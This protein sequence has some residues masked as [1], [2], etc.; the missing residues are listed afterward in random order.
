MNQP[1][2]PHTDTIPPHTDTVTPSTDPVPSCIN[3]Y[4]PILTWY[5][6]SSSQYSKVR[7]SFVNL[8]WA[9]LYVSLVFQSITLS[10]LHPK[11]TMKYDKHN[12]VLIAKT[13][14][15]NPCDLRAHLIFPSPTILTF[16]SHGLEDSNL[17]DSDILP[18]HC[19]V[20]HLPLFLSRQQHHLS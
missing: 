6:N 15:N 16:S 10:L 5:K 17:A 12:L 1:V 18:R 9:Q 8:R 19:R 4:R 7:L 14:P 11:A 2:S 13:T 3:Q 20:E